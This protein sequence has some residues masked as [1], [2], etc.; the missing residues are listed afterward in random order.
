MDSWIIDYETLANCTVLCAQHYKNP[1]N[2][3]I[4]VISK[5]RDDSFELVKFLNENIINGSYYISFNGNAFDNHITDYIHRNHWKIDRGEDFARDIYKYA[6]ALIKDSDAD[7]NIP[8]KSF[9]KSID[10]FKLNHWDNAAKRSSLKWIQYSM[11][12]YNIQE[13]PIH[14]TTEINTIDKLDEVIQY[15]IN[16]VKAT[17]KIYELSKNAIALRKHLSKKY[18]KFLF[19]N[20]E[21]SIAKTIFLQILSSKVQ[22]DPYTYKELML[23]ARKSKTFINVS[24]IILPIIEFKLP[25]F[26]LVLDQFK[27]LC[28]NTGSTKGGFKHSMI[29]KD[30]KTD[31]G[32]GGVH[33]AA[34]PGIYTADN[35]MIIMSSDV[36]SF[37]PNLAITNNWSPDHIPHDIFCQEYK[38]LY[39]QRKKIPKEDPTNYV[40]KIILNSTYGLS[41]DRNSFLYDPEFTMKIT[42]NGQLTLMMLY[43][44]LSMGIPES[45]PLMQNTDG[46]EMLI[47]AKYKDKYLEICK[48]WEKITMLSL[49]HTEYKKLILA[50]VNNYIAVYN[51]NVKCTPEELIKVKQ[52]NPE[53]ICVNDDNDCY[54]TPTKCKG[55]FEFSNLALHKNKSFLIIPKA[56]YNYFVLDILPEHTVR[57]NKNIFDYC[58]GIKAKGEW[59]FVETC[60]FN[61]NVEQNDLQKIVRYYISNRGCK[62]VKVNR[63]DKREIQVE[64]G[65]WLQTILNYY[66]P[67]TLW[68]NYDINQKYYLDKIYREIENITQSTKNQQL[69]LF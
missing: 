47:P 24:S 34:E 17:S 26:K 22:T 1:D 3:K 13:M 29:H 14:H 58:A 49:E 53:Y 42:I 52:K 32:L 4:F 23:A 69:K 67:T 66:N 64:S 27:T 40:Y 41:N 61:G 20:S 11:D 44:M 15:C 60:A 62:I 7:I 56:V 48:E 50:D 57:D 46:I 12:W 25:E 39:E 8:S 9:V 16:D 54:Y 37:Y 45:K 6:Q 36:A 68:E 35:D 43:E 59:K 51:K 2:M 10:L 30:V 31:F 63:T 65:K 33:G 19:S 18:N 28:I 38:E 21:P 5:M 55:R